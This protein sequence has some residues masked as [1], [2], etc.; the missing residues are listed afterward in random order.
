MSDVDPV[1]F[2]KLIATVEANTNAVRS[3]AEKLE[4]HIEENDRWIAAIEKKD[5][6]RKGLILGALGAGTVGGAT[7]GEALKNMIGHIFK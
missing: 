7:L 1:M 6:K 2:G 4:A 5:E 3:L